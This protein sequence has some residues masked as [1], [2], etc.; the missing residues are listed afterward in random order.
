MFIHHASLEPKWAVSGLCMPYGRTLFPSTISER[1][2]VPAD[3]PSPTPNVLGV[4]K[5]TE[6]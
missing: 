3:I 6:A 1:P 2:A 5:E 4:A